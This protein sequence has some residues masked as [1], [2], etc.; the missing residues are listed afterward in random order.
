MLSH[1]N[2]SERA[3]SVWESN[4]LSVK[5]VG[6]LSD[7]SQISLHVCCRRSKRS[8]DGDE[9]E[10]EIGDLELHD[11]RTEIAVVSQRETSTQPF[12]RDKWRFCM[13]KNIPG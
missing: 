4:G 5:F 1:L 6:C 3:T 9:G 7:G 12:I 8:R 10:K 13:I 2:T 11:D